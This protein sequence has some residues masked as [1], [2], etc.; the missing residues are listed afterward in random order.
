MPPD[1]AGRYPVGIEAAADWRAWRGYH[2]EP[3]PA[4]VAEDDEP[5]PTERNPQ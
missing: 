2:P 4:E 1:R 5:T 3:D